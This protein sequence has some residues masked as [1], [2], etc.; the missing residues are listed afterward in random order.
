MFKHTNNTKGSAYMKRIV[1]VLA[2]TLMLFSFAACEAPEDKALTSLGKYY[3][4]VFY[5]EGVFQDFTDYAKY[6]YT[7]ANVD[8]NDYFAK[9]KNPT[10]QR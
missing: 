6:Y 8:G 5:S 10:L 3:D 7:A 4:H 1:S 2:L 9:F